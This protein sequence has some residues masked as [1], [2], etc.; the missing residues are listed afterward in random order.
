MI[1]VI[2]DAKKQKCPQVCLET[3]LHVHV[4]ASST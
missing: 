3:S 2:E 4:V 1:V